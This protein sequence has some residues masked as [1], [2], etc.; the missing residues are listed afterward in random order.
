[1]MQ[2]RGDTFERE[3]KTQVDA[4]NS[5]KDFLGVDERYKFTHFMLGGMRMGDRGA[6]YLGGYA[7]YR[8]DT[9]VK[10]MS[11][12]Q[13]LEH[14]ESFTN[15]TQQSP[16]PFELSMTLASQNPVVHLMTVFTQFPTQLFN[17]EMRAIANWRTVPKTE[18]AR[19]LFVYHILLPQL[20]TLTLN[21]FKWDN[22]DNLA[23]LILGPFDALYIVG[24]VMQNAI[25]FLAAKALRE[26]APNMKI[27]GDIVESV[28]KSMFDLME[29]VPKVFKQGGPSLKTSLEI[30]NDL[31]IA[32]APVTGAAGG[33]LRY[34]TGV[35]EGA[36]R[37]AREDYL[38]AF[39]KWMGYSNYAVTK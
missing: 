15:S 29:A 27:G 17:A 13:A 28:A 11:H 21:R 35:V 12:E 18:T 37:A 32:T 34:G 6:I 26:K 16:D 24:D 7:M 3:I 36:R 22:V 2:G 33:L 10:K 14:F 23:A 39:W 9:E 19:K 8:Y 4:I 5:V 31:A 1:M 25:R 30:I 38:N 20:W